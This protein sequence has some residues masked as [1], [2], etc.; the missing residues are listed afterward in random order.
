[1]S[2]SIYVY[3][4]GSEPEDE[5]AQKNPEG[6]QEEKPQEETGPGDIIEDAPAGTFES[7]KSSSTFSSRTT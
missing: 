3:A 4:E 5:D 1:M 6:K 7:A 2:D